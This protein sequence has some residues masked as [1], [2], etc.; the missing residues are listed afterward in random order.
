MAN[1]CGTTA[2]GTLDMFLS[3]EQRR[4]HAISCE[5][6]MVCRKPID[7][8]YIM[9]S[10]E[11][12]SVW[13]GIIFIRCGM[14][15]GGMLRFVLTLQPDFPHT[16]ALPEVVFDLQ[17][18]HPHVFNDSR[19]VDF[20]R[21]FP[22]GWKRDYHHIH[23][24]LNYFQRFFFFFDAEA[25]SAAN[26]EAAILYQTN[27]KQFRKMTVETI[28]KSR[29]LIYELPAGLDKNV[30]VM[31]PWDQ[32]VHEAYRQS[33]LKLATDPS[34]KSDKNRGLSW[35]SYSGHFMCDMYPSSALQGGLPVGESPEE[36][37]EEKF[38]Q[39]DLTK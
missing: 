26:P 28:R 4:Q 27:K 13:N 35:L 17:V 14:F 9:P 23:H 15:A 24:V 38:E 11:N 21:H 5:Y 12:S 30:I 7:G 19:R 2:G 6:A 37:T 3:E 33:L 29:E 16:S 36:S 39:L 25:T 1:G 32:S 18:F 34:S 20:S 8:V 31:T 22:D 10:A